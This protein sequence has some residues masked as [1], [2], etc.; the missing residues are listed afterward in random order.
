MMGPT[1]TVLLSFFPSHSN[2]YSIEWD[3]LLFEILACFLAWKLPGFSTEYQPLK[4]LHDPGTHHALQLVASANA[5]HYGLWKSECKQTMAHAQ[6]HTGL[7]FSYALVSPVMV[8]KGW[9]CRHRNLRIKSSLWKH[10]THGPKTSHGPSTQPA[11]QALI[12]S[13]YF[14]K[15]MQ[16]DSH[17]SL[18]VI[19]P[20]L[21][22][23][24][25]S[26]F[27]A[28]GCTAPYAN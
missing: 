8:L 13:L 26:K 1:T 6:A 12:R 3:K 19:A 16:M 14:S 5:A 21:V 28:V 17:A 18:R 11:R 4:H 2:L 20:K 24:I 10:S 22:L 9:T 15:Q 23:P 7:D 27:T 25:L